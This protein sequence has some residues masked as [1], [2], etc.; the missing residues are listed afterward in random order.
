MF[1]RPGK[2]PAKKNQVLMS[3]SDDLDG[4]HDLWLYH[5]TKTMGYWGWL[6]NQPYYRNADDLA[7][8]ATWGFSG[9]FHV[10]FPGFF[11]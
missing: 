8:L 1:T 9:I 3:G 11:L 5:S 4:N 2:K 10:D 7:D 6:T